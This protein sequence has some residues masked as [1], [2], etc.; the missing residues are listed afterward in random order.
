MSHFPVSVIH[1]AD[2][3]V[4]AL[5][6]PYD[7]NIE[8]EP[9]IEYTREQA[10][11]HARKY[12]AE[13]LKDAS[14][15]ECWN[16]MAEDYEPDRVDADGNLW[17]TYNPKPKWDWWSFGGR[18]SGELITKSGEY[19]DECLVKELDVTLNKVDYKNALRFWDIHVD[20]KPMND[21]EKE[22]VCFIPYKPEYYIERY[23]DRET[24]AKC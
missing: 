10:I 1:R 20:H 4:E 13:R 14:D 3:D 16:D 15:E 12:R 19:T 7:E 9:Y 11:E 2:Q 21:D 18:W 5:L 24:Y 17:S 22:D 23:G 8:V 6:A